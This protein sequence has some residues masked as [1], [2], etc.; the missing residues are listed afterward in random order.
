MKVSESLHNDPSTATEDALHRAVDTT[1]AS[2]HTARPD[3]YLDYFNRGW[4]DFLGKLS[5]SVANSVRKFHL[6]QCSD[7]QFSK[8]HTGAASPDCG[9][10]RWRHAELTHQG[11]FRPL[12]RIQSRDR[13]QRIPEPN[14]FLVASGNEGR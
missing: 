7:R 12:S 3:G 5:G 9:W 2:I 14:T 8:R 13:L 4:L 10:P 11:E 6:G 1:P